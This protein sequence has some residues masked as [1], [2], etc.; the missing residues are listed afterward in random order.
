[1]AV[2]RP[3]FFK[4]GLDFRADA[5]SAQNV[6]EHHSSM[7]LRLPFTCPGDVQLSSSV[8]R[9]SSGGGRQKKKRGKGG[10]A[11]SSVIR[12][13][14]SDQIGVFVKFDQVGEYEVD[15]FGKKSS[16]GG[17]SLGHLCGVLVRV[18]ADG[19]TA[20]GASSFPLLYGAAS[21]FTECFAIVSP[22]PWQGSLRADTTVDKIEVVC[23][24]G[25]AMPSDG[26]RLSIMGDWAD[27]LVESGNGL[28][29]AEN[30]KITGGNK[31]KGVTLYM[32][33]PDGG[34]SYNGICKWNVV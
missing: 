11:T 2:F 13:P 27:N 10:L 24:G 5:K 7:P 34:G 3:S 29:R 32:K 17:S 4:L 9:R 16:T 23:R 14:D 12:K 25:P 19:V 28:W 6:I 1:M 33:D 20:G 8:S 21:R 31:A 15:L 22:P 26:L 30:V 18:K